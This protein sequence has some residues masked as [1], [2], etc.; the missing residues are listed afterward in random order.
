MGC[1]WD[2]E[3]AFIAIPGVV[4]TR[5]G[6]M[7]GTAL[8]PTY[9]QVCAG[10]TGHAEVVRIEYDPDI[11][12]YAELLRVFWENHGPTTLNRQGPDIGDQYRSAIFYGSPQQRKLA[13]DSMHEIRMSERYSTSVATE[14]TAAGPFYEAE[15][16]H[17]QY[18]RNRGGGAC[19]R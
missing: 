17:Q 9:E 5:V 18:F 6:F 1:F 19:F 16:Y 15:D 8:D 2:A 13:E 7:G 4:A 10:R 11:I 14:L 12:G 3:E